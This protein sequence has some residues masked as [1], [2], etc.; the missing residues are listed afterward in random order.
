MVDQFARIGLPDARPDLLDVPV[1]DVEVSIDG[2]VQQVAA[3]A[4]EAF[5]QQIERLNLLE[6]E[7]KTDGL[8]VHGSMYDV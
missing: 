7:P 8:L 5:S 2:L 6:V 4:I 3:V 1:L